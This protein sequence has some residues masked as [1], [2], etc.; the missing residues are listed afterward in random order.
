MQLTQFTDYSLRMLIYLARLPE[1]KI[2][3]LAEI[4]EFH[5]ISRNHLVK[6]AVTLTREGYIMTTRGKSGGM[7]LARPAHTISLGELIRK[8]EQ[9]MILVECFDPPNNRCR[10]S[11]GCFLKS[12]LYE[13]QLAFIS[14]LDKHTLAEASGMTL[15][16]TDD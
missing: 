15:E 8:T 4:A 12:A 14:V 6:V 16:P 10:L 2:A 5:N 11:R 13:A 1:G 7:Q 3:T 9:N